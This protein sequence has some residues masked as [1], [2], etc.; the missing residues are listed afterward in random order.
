MNCKI[1]DYLIARSQKVVR[2]SHIPFVKDY[3][4]LDILGQI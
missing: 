2:T 4:V 3:F 1:Y